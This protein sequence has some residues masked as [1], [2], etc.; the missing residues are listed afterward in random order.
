MEGIARTFFFIFISVFILPFGILIAYLFFKGKKQAWKGEIIDKKITTTEDFDTDREETH[1][2][3]IIKLESGRTKY[4]EVDR[5]KYDA[6]EIGD[7]L[8]KRSG[9]LWPEKVKL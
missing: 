8:E 3:I 9:E 4:L 7:K 6:W 5:T 2:K 1:F